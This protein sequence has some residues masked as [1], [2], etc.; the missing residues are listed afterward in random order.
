MQQKTKRTQN[1]KMQ[2]ANAG[3]NIF[4]CVDFYSVNGLSLFEVGDNF[5]IGDSLGLRKRKLK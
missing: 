4:L 2:C 1:K 3:N 5:Y